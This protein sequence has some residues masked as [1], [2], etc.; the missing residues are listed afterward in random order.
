MGARGHPSGDSCA[1]GQE[2]ERSDCPLLA[3]S[4]KPPALAGLDRAVRPDPVSH[5]DTFG[6]LCPHKAFG[7]GWG[8]L[9]RI[10]DRLALSVIG[11][12]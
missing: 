12:L 9:G 2:P 11:R 5:D 1:S 10:V 3:C 6:T 8:G 7:L 4:A